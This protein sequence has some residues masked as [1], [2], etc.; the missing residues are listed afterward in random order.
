MIKRALAAVAASM[1]LVVGLA[2]CGTESQGNTEPTDQLELI[3]GWTSA[4]SLLT[5]R[6]YRSIVM[7]PTS[8]GS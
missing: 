2:A 7:G 5:E 8:T 3:S 1:S 4:P 6:R